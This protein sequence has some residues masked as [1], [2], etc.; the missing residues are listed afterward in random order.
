MVSTMTDSGVPV[1]DAADRLRRIG[2]LTDT[3]LA[4]LDL[5]KLLQELLERVRDVLSADTAQVLLC[6]E[7]SDQ[8]VPTT[9]VGLEEEV[10]QGVRIRLGSGFFGAIAKHKEPCTLDCVDDTTMVS[11][12]LRDKGITA[13]LGV[14]M[15]AGGDLVGVLHVGTYARR[16]FTDEDTHLLQLVADRMALAIRANQSGTERVVA[17]ALQRSLLPARLPDVPGLTLDARY[18]PGEDSG[19]GG[20]WYDVFTLPSGRLGIVIGDVVGNGL[21]AAVVMGRLRS[22]LRAYALETEDPAEV[23][24]KLD[25]KATHFE[26]NTM[27]TVAYGVLDPTTMRLGISLAGHPAPACASTEGPTVLI[28]APVDPPVGLGMVQA[29]RCTYQ[30]DMSPGSALCFF[31]DGL[32]ER[33]DSTI[34]AGFDRLRAALKPDHAERVCE[35]LMSRLIGNATVA[36]DVAVLVLSLNGVAEPVPGR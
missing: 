18:V 10:R 8:L 28:D 32:V 27:A 15:L 3:A 25:R 24:T 1:G 29:P 6:E 14:P 23:L 26:N 20:D 9:S 19:V 30:L 11:S 31:T 2:I 16:M 13:L 4:R 5:D 22:V 17:T 7:E 12:V 35:R 36:D 34:D 21:A 33:R